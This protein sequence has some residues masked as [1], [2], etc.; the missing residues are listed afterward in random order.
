MM[1]PDQIREHLRFYFITDDS[2]DGFPAPDQVRVALDAGATLIQYRNKS[3]SLND[4]EEVEA[5]C[6]LCRQRRV[7]FVVNDDVLLARAAGA[8]GVHVGQEDTPP[9]LARRIMGP[10]AI[11]GVSVSSM[12][13]L[14]RTDL[15]SCDYIGTGPTFPTDTKRDAK[16]VHGLSGLRDIVNLS[17]LPAV[18]I[19]GIDPTNALDCF[20][21]GAAGVAVIS[22]ITRIEDPRSA[23]AAMASACG[24]APGGARS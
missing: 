14:E 11:V 20:A 21:H 6:R 1:T 17:P 5:I 13:E 10:G 3:F 19:G 2:V 15:A 8:D 4:F 12:E 9:R 23:A 7:P 24:V 18:A 22:C 16:A